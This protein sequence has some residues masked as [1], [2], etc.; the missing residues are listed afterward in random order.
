MA[1]N[2]IQFPKHHNVTLSKTDKALVE[3]PYFIFGGNYIEGYRKSNYYGGWNDFKGRFSTLEK[4]IAFG[5][6][7]LDWYHIV[8]TRTMLI[9]HEVS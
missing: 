4:A 8:D 5:M 9:V 1:D 6:K 2:V 3:H 7:A